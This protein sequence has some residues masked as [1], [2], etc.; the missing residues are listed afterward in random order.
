MTYPPRAHVPDELLSWLAEQQP[1][2]SAQVG[3]W[4]RALSDSYVDSHAPTAAAISAAHRLTAYARYYLPVNYPKLH[5]PLAELALQESLD[6]LRRE[7]LRVLDLGCGPGTFLLS[8][9]GFLGERKA[10][11]KSLELVGVD[12]DRRALSLLHDAC[13]WQAARCLPETDVRVLTREADLFSPLPVEYRGRGFDVIV[14]GNALAEWARGAKADAAAAS[15]RVKA[16]LS[17]LREGGALIVIEPALRETSRFLL[18][19]R[20]VLLSEG[21]VH[22]YAPCL[23]SA[24]CPAL[25]RERDWCHER[26]DWELPRAIEEIDRAAGLQKGSLAFSYLVLRRE[27]GSLADLPGGVPAGWLRARV[28]SDQLA[29]KGKRGCIA[30]TQG[31]TRVYYETLDRKATRATLAALEGLRRGSLAAFAPGKP[32]GERTR[33]GEG[34]APLPLLA[35]EAQE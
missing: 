34:E 26:L 12:I 22:L 11:P 2:A 19:V 5:L 15:A 7:K 6:P 30:C 35:P 4:V 23:H 21:A 32:A 24:P 14:I 20:D 9:L 1:G 28:V 25:A 18:E 16:A 27:A 13:E 3:K 29:E 17:M 8:V 10:C 33:L 31:G